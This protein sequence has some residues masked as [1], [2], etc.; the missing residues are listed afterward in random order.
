MSFDPLAVETTDRL[1]VGMIEQLF[2]DRIGAVV[3][4]DFV[5]MWSCQETMVWLSG[6]EMGRYDSERY[7]SDAYRLGPTLNEHRAGGC[8]SPDYWA[9]A[10]AVRDMWALRS[11]PS[12]IR[13]IVADRLA[14]LA[15]VV[16]P[17]TTGGREL[18]WGIIR[19][20]SKGTLIH[21]DDV[22]REFP[23]LF[24]D[25][26]PV[27]QLALNIFLSV[28]E[29][30]GETLIWRHRWH[31]RDERHR[32]GFGYRD[33]VVGSEVPLRVTPRAGDGVIFD[34]RR[35]H[36]VR[37]GRGGRRIAFATFLGTGDDRI[38]LWS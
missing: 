20:I 17:A 12:S 2:E 37:T 28:P 24:L 4:P 22:R 13:R 21:W 30:G 11:S 5:P 14:S 19:E 31:E 27:E 35:Y 34:S 9:T 26:P 8:L 15:G 29:N 3:V 7:E 1:T 18:F 6:I 38:T 32:I 23:P 10:E 25:D 36:G 33:D 16:R